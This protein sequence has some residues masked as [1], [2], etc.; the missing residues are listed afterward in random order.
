MNIQAFSDVMLHRLDYGFQHRWTV[1]HLNVA[2]T[3]IFGHVCEPFT[4]RKII[5]SQN[6]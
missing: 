5:T 4:Q 6:N 3:E 2:G 1:A